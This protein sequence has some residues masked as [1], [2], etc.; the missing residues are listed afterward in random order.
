MSDANASCSRAKW[1]VRVRSGESNFDRWLIRRELCGLKTSSP[2][3]FPAFPLGAKRTRAIPANTRRVRPRCTRRV[4]AKAWQ[5]RFAF[6]LNIIFVLLLFFFTVNYSIVEKAFS[7]STFFSR[8]SPSEEN[9]RRI[10]HHDLWISRHPSRNIAWDILLRLNMPRVD[11]LID[12]YV[13]GHTHT[14][15]RLDRVCRRK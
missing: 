4:Y 12:I 10:S 13:C 11:T 14:H 1:N 5:N 15:I 7:A 9:S 8:L 3:N 6:S 2:Y